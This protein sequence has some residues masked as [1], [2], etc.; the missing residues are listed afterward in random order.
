MGQLMS[1]HLPKETGVYKERLSHWPN[2][3]EA[4]KTRSRKVEFAV[5][6]RKG[7]HDLEEKSC[8]GGGS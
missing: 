3:K 7:L 4:G 5:G 6:E 1:S 2:W 8:V